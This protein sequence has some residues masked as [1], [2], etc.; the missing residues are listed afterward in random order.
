MSDKLKLTAETR[1]EFGKGAARRIRAAHQIPAVIYGHGEDPLHVVLPGHD[2]MMALKHPNALLTIELDG[3]KQLAIAKDVQRDPIKPVIV[4]VDL[5]TVKKGEKITVDVPV[6]LEGESAPGTIHVL[7]NSTLQVLA[8]AT[9][10]PEF[11]TVSI[12]GLEE[13]A[14]VTAAEVELPQ[15]TELAVDGELLVV[16]VTVPRAA[17][18]DEAEAPEGDVVPATE[19]GDGPS[20]APEG[21]EN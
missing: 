12:E 9:H 7:E 2:T 17:A 3:D 20:E 16:H 21:D 11:F 13:G 6:H 8:E 5:L 18:D 10:I 15:G 19:E 4:H 1:T 14:K